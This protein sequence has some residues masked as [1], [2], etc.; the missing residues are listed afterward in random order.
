MMYKLKNDTVINVHNIMQATIGQ[1]I[2]H[3][4]INTFDFE[5]LISTTFLG[6]DHGCNIN[7]KEDY[8]PT[9]FET[10][11]FC[12]NIPENDL[13]YQERYT[14]Y[15]EAICGHYIA[16]RFFIGFLKEYA[17]KLKSPDEQLKVNHGT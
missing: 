15:Y 5:A 13:F 6:V 17:N 14:D 1:P 9:I 7:N 2:L 11:I 4:K 8:K 10:M 16:I 3:T 12:A